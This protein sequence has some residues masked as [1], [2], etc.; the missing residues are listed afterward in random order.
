MSYSWRTRPVSRLRDRTWAPKYHSD[1]GALVTQFYLPALT[2]AARYDRTTGY[3]T[4]SALTLAARGV[5]GLIK[6]GGHMRLVVGCMLNQPEVDAIERGMALRE[7]VAARLAAVP[8]TAVDPIQEGALE[9]VAWMVARS[10]LDVKVAVPCGVDG[11]PAAVEGIFHEK[12]GVI[13]DAA[14]DALDELLSHPAL[15][16]QTVE[17]RPLGRREYEIIMPGMK[18]PLRVT[19]SR[20]NFEEHPGT[21]ELWSPGSPLFPTGAELGEPL[22]SPIGHLRDLLRSC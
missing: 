3:F 21:Y 11:K 22:T 12:A 16:P 14:R 13:E 9:L 6:N 18:E 5:E 17:R 4:A 1:A 7:A 20:E 19:T 15:L 10:I 2:C 8:L